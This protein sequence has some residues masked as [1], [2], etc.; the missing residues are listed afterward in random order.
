MQTDAPLNDL[1]PPHH[2]APDRESILLVRKGH[3]I[4]CATEVHWLQIPAPTRGHSSC[5]SSCCRV[6]SVY[7]RVGE[8]NGRICKGRRTMV[9]MGLSRT[10]KTVLVWRNRC[11]AMMRVPADVPCYRTLVSSATAPGIWP[12]VTPHSS[13][14]K[15]GLCPCVASPAS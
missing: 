11:G 2:V 8:M 3:P 9:A 14:R 10:L 5:V 7:S 13:S 4:A 12:Q 1:T 15:S 6:T